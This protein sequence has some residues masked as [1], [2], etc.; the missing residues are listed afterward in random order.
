MKNLIIIYGEEDFLVKEKTK[1]VLNQLLKPEEKAFGLEKISAENYS[2]SNLFQQIHTPPAFSPKKVI[3][4]QDCG[5]F[6]LKADDRETKH[7]ETLLTHLAENVYVV[8]EILE[9]VDGRKKLNKFLL[10]EAQTFSFP[11]IA[12]WEE[13]KFID[14]IIETVKK[15]G[16]TIGLEEANQLL[17][18]TG[19]HLGILYSEI[20]KLVSASLGSTPLTERSRGEKGGQDSPKIITAQL[21]ESLASRGEVRAFALSEYYRQGRL[22]DALVSM[23]EALKLNK[24]A[25]QILGQLVNMNRLLIQLRSYLN[26]GIGYDEMA[27]ETGKNVFFIKRIVKEMPAYFAMDYLLAAHSAMA[28]A[29]ESI[30]S[31]KLSPLQALRQVFVEVGLKHPKIS[32]TLA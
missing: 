18:C 3:F 30:K 10:S 24:P 6:D 12:E 11:K 29:D 9:N 14:F 23:E 22:R 20:Q 25:L 28:M 17:S 2:Y 1:E 27:S 19:P 5:P 15:N 26:E 4:C 32:A 7:Y 21:I 8:F 13:Q 31:G 16:A